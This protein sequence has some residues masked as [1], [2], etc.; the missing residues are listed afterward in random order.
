MFAV[1]HIRDVSGP[2]FT[3]LIHQ[4]TVNHP[5]MLVKGASLSGSMG[6]KRAL[7]WFLSRVGPHVGSQG[8]HLASLVRA[9]WAGEG[10]FPCVRSYVDLQLGAGV[11]MSLA[12][13]TDSKYWSALPLPL[14]DNRKRHVT[15]TVSAS[16]SPTF[17]TTTTINLIPKLTSLLWKANSIIST[18]IKNHF[19]NLLYSINPSYTNT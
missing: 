8:G 9:V 12:Y 7:E 2:N 17:T 6:T 5:D 1:S 14:E 15:S 11:K 16:D 19:I 3:S 18:T 4:R 13:G 10:S